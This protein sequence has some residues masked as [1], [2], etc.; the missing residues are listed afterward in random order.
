MIQGGHYQNG[1]T[2]RKGKDMEKIKLN[3]GTIFEIQ[4]NSSEYN[5]SIIAY[6]V[7]E[8][9][10]AFTDENLTR[11]EILTENYSTC[12]IYT[13]KHLKKLGAESTEDG[14]LVTLIFEDV[15]DIYERVKHLEA[16]V[17]TLQAEIEATK[18]ETETEEIVEDFISEDEITEENLESE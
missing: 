2:Y 3:D 5:I 17:E 13:K 10:A 11:Y 15:N 18:V 14:Y 7:D 1:L 12:A 9:I 8:V 6:S 4:P 16:T